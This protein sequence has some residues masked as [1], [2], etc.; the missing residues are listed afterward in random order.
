MSI[1]NSASIAAILGRVEAP[2]VTVMGHTLKLY[3]PDRDEV[4]GMTIEQT[5]VE[6]SDDD[7]ALD[8]SERRRR[9]VKRTMRVAERAI[10][11]CVPGLESEAAAFGLLQASGGVAGELAQSCL[12]LCGLGGGLGGVA[13]RDPTRSLSGESSA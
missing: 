9:D 3:R 11:M 6:L 13:G 12:A 4:E 2:E 7:G 1:D 8:D 5:E 10:S